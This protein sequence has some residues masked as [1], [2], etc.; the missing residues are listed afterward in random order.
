MRH[1]AFTERNPAGVSGYAHAS[2][3]G[4]LETWE[5]PG[6]SIKAFYHTVLIGSGMPLSVMDRLLATTLSQSMAR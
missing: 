4:G 5:L 1:S 2:L 6:F 3:A